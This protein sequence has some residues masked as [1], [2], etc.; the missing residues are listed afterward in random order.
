MN[1]EWDHPLLV[2]FTELAGI[3][4]TVAIF[5]IPIVIKH[6]CTNNISG[7]DK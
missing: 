6:G 4:L 7:K 5:T 2:L 3:C 1:I